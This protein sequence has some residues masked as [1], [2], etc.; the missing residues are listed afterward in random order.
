MCYY[1]RP[2]RRPATVVVN[3][4]TFDPS[5][6][7]RAKNRA[8]GVE[9]KTDFDRLYRYVDWRRKKRDNNENRRDTILL[10]LRDVG[11][12]ISHTT[13]WSVIPDRRSVGR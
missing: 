2:N 5:R 13:P 7:S 1:C 3:V 12:V 4:T 10:A 8:R 6:P 9:N 11:R